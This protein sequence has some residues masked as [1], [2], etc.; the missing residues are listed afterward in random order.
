GMTELTTPNFNSAVYLRK[1]LGTPNAANSPEWVYVAFPAG[2]Y[3][4]WHSHKTGQV[5]IAT[6]GIGYHQIKGGALEVL[7]PGN[8]V[9][10]P[11][12]V[13][14]WHGA[15]PTS[16]FAHIAISPQDNH[17]VTWYDFPT[18]EYE[19]IVPE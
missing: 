7:H 8:V 5:L 1:I 18:A 16:K 10:C 2:T 9:F 11:P 15:S 6:D 4:R 19:A 3:N 13:V 17:D 14:H 12:N